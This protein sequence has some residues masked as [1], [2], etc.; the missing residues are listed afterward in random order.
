MSGTP[1]RISISYLYVIFRRGYPHTFQDALRTL[2]EIQ[3]LGFRFLEMEGLGVKLLK[4]L[5]N[6]RHTL[7]RALQ[8][9]GLHVHNFCVVN[10]GLVSLDRAKRNRAIDHF[11][12]GV[13]LGTLLEAETLHLA[14]YAPPVKYVG[15]KPYQL[16]VKS[17]YKFAERT[18]VRLPEGFDWSAVWRALVESCQA[19]ADVAAEQNKTVLM[20]PRIGEVI[21]SVDSL[22]RLI[23]HVKRD[24]FK[25]NF[26]TGHFS[27]QREDVVLALA[28]LKG[29]FANIHLSD[30]DPKNA[31][32]LP[33]GRGTIDWLEFFRTLKT[34][35]YRGYLGLDLGMSGTLAA[36]YRRSVEYVQ[37][38]AS[39]LS[40]P[41][42]V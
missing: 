39:K 10:P 40:I 31:N 6:Q 27:A 18:R 19:C 11:K 16:G 12:T 3:K 28:K 32:H 4:S 35:D 24:N 38:L 14:S 13:E 17:G 21:C 42:E 33:I 29:H 2:P 9:S 34:M 26:D 25:A 7:V 23:E 30:N 41:T 1:M 15:T 5:Y 36:D 20:E 37:A 8:D 22:L